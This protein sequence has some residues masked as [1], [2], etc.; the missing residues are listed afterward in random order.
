MELRKLQ[1]SIDRVL[2]QHRGRRYHV[3][4]RIKPNVPGDYVEI[5]LVKT[6]GRE[7]DRGTFQLSNTQ[8]A[9]MSPFTLSKILDTKI[10]GMYPGERGYEHMQTKE[11]KEIKSPVD[12]WL[13]EY[14]RRNMGVDDNG[15]KA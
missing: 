2:T 12:D 4:I 1:N 11:V 9:S 5:E 3:E 15:Q 13:E 10:R 6:T 14:D 7:S 8:L